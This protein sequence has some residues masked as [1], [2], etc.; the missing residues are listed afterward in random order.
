[1][2][3]SLSVCSSNTQVKRCLLLL[4][5]L[6]NIQIYTKHLQVGTVVACSLLLL[7]LFANYKLCVNSA[8]CLLPP[9]PP[10][11]AAALGAL[12]QVRSPRRRRHRRCQLTATAE[13]N[14]S[15]AK[16]LCAAPLSLSSTLPFLPS[17]YADLS[18]CCSTPLTAAAAAAALFI[19]EPLS[20]RQNCRVCPS[21]RTTPSSLTLSLPDPLRK[22]NC[23]SRLCT[24]CA[25]PYPVYPVLLY[26]RLCFA[27][28]LKSRH[29][30]R[31]QQ[32]VLSSSLSTESSL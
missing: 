18:A 23:R 14:C 5:L 15:K 20:T 10:P 9:A 32:L 12:G 3:I 7:L 11:P 26:A 13:E 22:C 6:L 31:H 24:L 2:P 28:E 16:S 21:Q 29:Q 4:L 1:M 30:A 17:A 27:F 8:A 19:M 25:L